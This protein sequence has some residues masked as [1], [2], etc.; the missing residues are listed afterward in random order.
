MLYNDKAIEEDPVLGIKR[1][2]LPLRNNLSGVNGLEHDLLIR[3]EQNPENQIPIQFVGAIYLLSKDMKSFQTFIEKYYGTSTLPSLPTSFQEAVILLAE[4]DS[5][6]WRR[7]NV[8][9][10]VIRK[11]TGYRNLVL[12]NRN[13]PQLPQLIKNSFGDTYWSYYL[14]K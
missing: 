7:F 9:E 1:K 4:K 5:D 3:A 8:S 14:L 10:N 13:N 2:G 6:Y 11:F 12:Q